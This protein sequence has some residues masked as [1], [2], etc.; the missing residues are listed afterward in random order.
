[1][2][3]ARNEFDFRGFE[4]FYILMDTN[5]LITRAID[6]YTTD[7]VNDTADIVFSTVTDRILDPDE[8]ILFSLLLLVR[9]DNDELNLRYHADSVTETA[10]RTLELVKEYG[11]A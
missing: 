3:V 7:E 1:M 2:T 8:I 6:T 11:L 5:D 9:L 10:V 4:R